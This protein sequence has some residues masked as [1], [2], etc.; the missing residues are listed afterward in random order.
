[1]KLHNLKNEPSQNTLSLTFTPVARRE[2]D[3]PQNTET[4]LEQS[5]EQS[6]GGLTYEGEG[7]IEAFL[8]MIRT[9][10]KISSR[11]S[12]MSPRTQA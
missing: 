9:L 8:N 11:W 2:T 3:V 4:Y 7:L 1:M 6:G 5:G 12:K 10:T